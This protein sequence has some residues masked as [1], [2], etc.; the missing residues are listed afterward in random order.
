MNS[1]RATRDLTN[2]AEVLKTDNVYSLTQVCDI[3]SLEQSIVLEFVDYD[4]IQPVSDTELLFAQ[5]QLDRLLK[6]IRLKR[7]L[8]LNHAGVALA[9]DLLETIDD[10]KSE[11]S[12]L[13][14]V[15]RFHPSID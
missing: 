12:R 13:H 7:D 14:N 3:C 2:L 4:V 8:E 15:T 10:L 9:L 5:A 11:I 6:A 1:K